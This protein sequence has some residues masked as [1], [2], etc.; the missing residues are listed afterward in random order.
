MKKL[1]L[2]ILTVIFLLSAFA[3]IAQITY[4]SIANNSTVAGGPFT[5]DDGRFWASPLNTP[6]PNPCGNCTIIINSSVTMVPDNGTSTASAAGTAPSLNH[7]VLTDSRLQIN[8][9][10]MVTINT[11]LDMSNT[12]VLVGSD[13][14][15]AAGV[16]LNDQVDLKGTSSI[17]LANVNTYVDANNNT[18][19]PINGPHVLFTLGT[20]YAGIYYINA[21][22]TPYG[23]T[24]TLAQPGNGSSTDGFSQY[25][26]NC[27]PAVP[28]SPNNCGQGIIFGPAITTLNG[29]QGLIFTQA[30]TLPVELV[31]FLA[32]KNADGSIKLLWATAQEI[33]SSSFD[34]ERSADQGDWQK[35]G[36]VKA[37]GYSST[38]ANYSYTDQFPLAGNGYYRLKMIDLDGKF[39]YSKVVVVSTD[40]NS[41][42][43][44]VYSNPFSDQIRVK[45]N[46]ARSQNL[47]LTVSDIIGKTYLKQSYNAQAGDNLINLVPNGAAG[48]MY[49]LHIQ[50]DTYEQTVKLVKQ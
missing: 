28:L 19:N 8:A 9:P 21:A 43:L 45:V 39:Q 50:G 10:A 41:Q 11:Y 49:V 36:S 15:S 14:T 32:S 42:P 48:G 23:Y 17:Q 26:L 24:A 3:S 18:G 2:L 31:Q 29:T 47:T 1:Y 4:S 44:V 22:Y 12:S 25:N 30:S 34:I 33:N 6:P 5:L 7:V 35:I 16:I 13:A 40:N 46:V 27:E 20:K 37:K 38:T